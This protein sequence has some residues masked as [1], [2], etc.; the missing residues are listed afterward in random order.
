[1]AEPSDAVHPIDPVDDGAGVERKQRPRRLPLFA[2]GFTA[3]VLFAV[4]MT[5]IRPAAD[6]P[7]PPAPGTTATA[8]EIPIAIPEATEPRPASPGLASSPDW[9][10]V[11]TGRFQPGVTSWVPVWT[12]AEIVFQRVS[13]ELVAYRPATRT[14]RQLARP[15]IEVEGASAV[16]AGGD[17]ILWSDGGVAAWDPET[18][19]WRVLLTRLFEPSTSRRIVW[20]GAEVVDLDASLAVDP[21]TGA[22]RP[23]ASAPR[24]HHE[25]AVAVW[26]GDRIVMVPSGATYD[27]A[28]DT[29]ADVPPSGLSPL[30]ADGVWTGSELFAA[31]YLMQ[32]RGTTRS[33]T[34]GRRIPSSRCG[35]PGALRPSTCSP[36]G[37]WWRIARV[38]PHG[39][40]KAV[41]G[42]RSRCPVC[43]PATLSFRP[44]PTYTR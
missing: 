8:T 7:P 15:P 14:W 19:D 30:T 31:D 26:A 9:V 3:V 10:P 2:A 29:W 22:T 40:R 12:G 1:M 25:R 28:T 23:I 16:R 24:P 35:S 33:T 27:P 32:A 38:S 13:G 39:T 36:V 18:D 5:L 34:R 37:P 20:T 43:S 11:G 21:A 41:T 44:P 4:L 17:L 42:C 6:L